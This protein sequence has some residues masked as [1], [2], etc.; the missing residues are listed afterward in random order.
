MLVNIVTKSGTTTETIANAAIFIELIAQFHPENYKDYIIVT[1]DTGSKLHDVACH[2]R[3]RVLEVPPLVGGRYSVFSAV[4]LFPLAMIGV[5]ID[6]LLR[7]AAHMVELCTIQ[8]GEQNIAAQS[9]VLFYE[10]YQR[11]YV[12]HNL[13][14]F[15]VDL[16]A[17]G[18]WCRQLTAESLGKEHTLDGTKINVGITPTVSVGSTDLHSIVELHLAGPD[19]TMTTFIS[20]GQFHQKMVVPSCKQLQ[21][22]VP[23]I[24][25]KSLDVITTA[26]LGG[27]KK[28]YASAR[29]PYM[30]VLFPSK[31]PEIIGQFMQW[32]MLETMYLGDLFNINPF[33]QPQVE[34]YKKEARVLLEL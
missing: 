13:F 23:H 34:L 8:D 19:N 32:K 17:L 26:L 24:Q 27:T 20:V 16:C 25:G 15:A 7:G 11:G 30:S 5:D 21:H 12:I 1:T 4:G 3:W 14:P 10:L 22:L 28:A 2:E 6:A 33:I 31:S 9:A 18:L 29:R